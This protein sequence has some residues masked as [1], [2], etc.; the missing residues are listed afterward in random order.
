MLQHR[1]NVLIESIGYPSK[2]GLVSGSLY[3]K[4]YRCPSKGVEKTSLGLRINVRREF[5][6]YPSKAVLVSD[7]L[8]TKAYRKSLKGR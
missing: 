2:A 4:A 7:S 3:T 5:I 6:A 1:I 8:Y